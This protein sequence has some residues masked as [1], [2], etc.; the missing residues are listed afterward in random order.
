MRWARLT[1][2]SSLLLLGTLPMA[3]LQAA[4]NADPLEVTAARETVARFHAQLQAST[5]AHQN[6]ELR[7]RM[8][9][10][11][12]EQTFDAGLIA[13]L[14]LG[15]AW[16]TLTETDRAAFIEALTGLI[17]ATYADRFV[18][19]AALQ[20]E[21][22]GAASARRGPLIETRLVR[23]SGAPVTLDYHF[24]DGKIYNVVADG[25]SDLS[26]RRA[27]YS[28][29]IKQRGFAALLEHVRAQHLNL[30]PGDGSSE[31]SP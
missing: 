9:L 8:L 31:P 4:P 7:Y 22:L 24:R 30:L 20:F 23:Q 28:T 14:S 3:G 17:A 25:V 26:L 29:V 15:R 16:S 18:P 1:A 19:G 6:V 5:V 10:S 2:L 12:V 21:L 13:R 11:A 27:D